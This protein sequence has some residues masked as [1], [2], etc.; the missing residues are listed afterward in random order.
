MNVSVAL[1]IKEL[2][3]LFLKISEEVTGL[4]Y[5]AIVYQ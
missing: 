2:N 1:E 5:W 4:S 3:G